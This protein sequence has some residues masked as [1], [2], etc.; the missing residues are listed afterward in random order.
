MNKK[1]DVK[2]KGQPAILYCRGIRPDVLKKVKAKARK[3]G[4]K[5]FSEFVN[6]LFEL[7]LDECKGIR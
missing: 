3:L 7:Y 5:N 4:Y 2:P 6:T 1:L